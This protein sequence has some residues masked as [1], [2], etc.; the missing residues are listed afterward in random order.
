MGGGGGYAQAG[1]AENDCAK[2]NDSRALI[3]QGDLIRDMAL[4]FQGSS[5]YGVQGD[6]TKASVCYGRAL[7]ISPTS[8]TA[9]FGLGV[10]FLAMAREYTDETMSMNPERELYLNAAKERLGKA[11]VLRAGSYEPV[12]YLA[13]TAVHEEDFDRAKLYLNT[14]VKAGYKL[15]PSYALKGYI[16]EQENNESEAKEFY[17][18]ALQSGWPVT[19]LRFAGQ[20]LE[21][22]GG[23]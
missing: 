17:E 20:R 12:Y 21:Q 8:Y 10:T 3:E 18:M 22:L 6:L 9:N 16:A 4:A 23:I 19:T 2:M 5:P 15:G 7:R 14:L 1:D 11:Y 13:E